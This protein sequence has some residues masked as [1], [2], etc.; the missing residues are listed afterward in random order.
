MTL[1]EIKVNRDRLAVIIGSKGATKMAVEK[2]TGTRIEIDSE[3][4]LVLVDS[5]DPIAVIRTVEFIRAVN[6]GFSPERADIILDDEDVILTIM[7]LSSICTTTK[8][9]ERFRGRIIGKAGKAR[10]QIEDMTG[11]KMSVY[12]K[13]V[14]IIG[15]PEQAMIAEEAV[16]MLLQGLPHANVFAFLD[17]KKKE[18]K[19]NVLDYYY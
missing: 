18:A 5:E 4:G 15:L 2:K 8:Q 19:H 16:R 9:M 12:N 1:Q 13:T 14:A 10:S 3:E 17:R 6:R 11:T 7:D